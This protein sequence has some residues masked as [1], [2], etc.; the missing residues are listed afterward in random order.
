[1]SAVDVAIARRERAGSREPG[2]GEGNAGPGGTGQ[3]PR[4]GLRERK[5]RQTRAAIFEAARALFAARGFEDVTVAE[6]A[7]AADISVKTLFTYVRSKEEL[8]FGGEPTVLDAVVAAIRDRRLGETPLVAAARALLAAAADPR[9]GCPPDAGLASLEGFSR[10]AA[11]GPEAASRLRALWA[12]AEDDLTQA[13][14]R[15]KDGPPERAARRL[16]AAQIMVL[17]RAATSAEVHDLVAAAG[18]GAGGQRARRE[19]L[20]GW[21]RDAAG[22]LARGLQATGR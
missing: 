6:I 8:V 21:I 5:R 19:A 14:A 18:T 4:E 15:A 10:M 12:Q 17:V 11:S 20:R 16:E 3:G 13:L 1:M 9:P 2:P 7:D 22:R